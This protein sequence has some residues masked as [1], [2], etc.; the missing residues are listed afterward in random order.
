MPGYVD[1]SAKARIL[2]RYRDG[3][4]LHVIANDYK[5]STDELRELMRLWG[6]PVPKRAKIG[7]DNSSGGNHAP[8][9]GPCTGYLAS[10]LVRPPDGVP[11]MPYPVRRLP[12]PQ[13]G[14][15]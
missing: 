2:R 13:R 11:G 1:P 3:V 5:I 6:H 7:P 8:A 4:A 10:S 12:S 14:R 9:V 15:Q